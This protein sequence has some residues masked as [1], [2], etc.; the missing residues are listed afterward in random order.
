MAKKTSNLKVVQQ[1]TEAELAK[2]EREQAQKKQKELEDSWRL[3]RTEIAGRAHALRLHLETFRSR[4]EGVI[5]DITIECPP[6]IAGDTPDVINLV[7]DFDSY[8]K[9]RAEQMRESE[10]DDQFNLRMDTAETAFQIGVMWGAMAT[11]ASDREIDRLERGLIH[12]TVS[13]GWRCKDR[14]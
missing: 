2:Y 11:G 12:A 13:R 3:T 1:P 9:G 7:D 10:H 14:G 6:S 8:I 5:F 4:L